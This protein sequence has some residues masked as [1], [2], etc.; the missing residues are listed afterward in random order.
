MGVRAY[1]SKG[2]GSSSW[3]PKGLRQPRAGLGAVGV[4]PA[5]DR[6]GPAGPRRPAALLSLSPEPLR[7]G[8]LSPSTGCPW[9]P[10]RAPLRP[11]PPRPRPR[12]GIS[13]FQLMCGS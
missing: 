8:T 1:M 10:G 12:C 3:P 11:S 6:S 4:E 13:N 9:S 2:Q 5:G 7:L